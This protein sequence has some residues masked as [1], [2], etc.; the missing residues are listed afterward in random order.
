MVELIGQNLTLRA[1]F[2][3]FYPLSTYQVLDFKLSGVHFLQIVYFVFHFDP[4]ATFS[5]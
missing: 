4:L 1:L 3:L 2:P 5:F